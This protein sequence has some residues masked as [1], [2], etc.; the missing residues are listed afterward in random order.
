MQCLSSPVSYRTGQ[1]SG[2]RTGRG[3]SSRS[4]ASGVLYPPPERASA[5][6]LCGFRGER[7]LG[8]GG[9]RE[10]ELRPSQPG[11]RSC[12]GRAAAASSAGAAA[13]ARAGCRP[14]A[15]CAGGVP[16]PVDASGGGC[17]GRVA[18]PPS[19]CPCCSAED[20]CGL[21]WA[22]AAGRDSPKE[23]SEVGGLAPAG[24]RA[25]AARAHHRG[26]SCGTQVRSGATCADEP[27]GSQRAAEMGRQ[28]LGQMWGRGFL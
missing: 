20:T 3:F 27:V 12:G 11:L 28:G 5:I 23:E 10:M 8:G 14:G 17:P 1:V 4:T 26:R 13:K 24:G 19:A 16:V 18:A 7:G 21:A 9:V 22:A 6:S 2:D 25:A 15:G